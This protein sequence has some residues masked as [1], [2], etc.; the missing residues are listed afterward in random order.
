MRGGR[1]IVKGEGICNEK[2]E[3]GERRGMRGTCD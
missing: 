1:D 3:E 2:T